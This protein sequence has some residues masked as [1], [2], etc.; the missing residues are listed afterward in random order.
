MDDEE[1]LELVELETR[2]MLSQYGFPG[3][4]CPFIMGSAL[5]ALEAMK[6]DT[7]FRGTTA[8]SSWAP[9]CRPWR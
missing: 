6:G 2:E 5:Q 3:D 7:G 9:R 8:P 4:D 1:L